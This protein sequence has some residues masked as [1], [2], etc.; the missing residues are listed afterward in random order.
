MTRWIYTGSGMQILWYVGWAVVAAIVFVLL[1]M[2]A[3]R[4]VYYPLK[5][6]SGFWD[7][8]GELAAEDVWLLTADGVRI[9]AWW[10]EAPQSSLVTLY[11]HGNAGNVT[12][13]F[14]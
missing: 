5:H 8:Q 2:A 3:A 4:M 13:S 14:G 6:P 10:V 11:L 9:H 12:H 7:L 1:S